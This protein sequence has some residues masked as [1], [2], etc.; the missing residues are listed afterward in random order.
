MPKQKKTCLVWV[1]QK[2]IG[3]FVLDKKARERKSLDLDMEI[4]KA[5]Q[6][7]LDSKRIMKRAIKTSSTMMNGRENAV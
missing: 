7:W 5:K 3:G 4:L 1:H 2:W 6:R